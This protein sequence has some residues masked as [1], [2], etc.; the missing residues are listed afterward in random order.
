MNN[1]ERI[2][3]VAHNSYELAKEEKDHIKKLGMLEGIIEFTLNYL[4]EEVN[5]EL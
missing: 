2:I 3:K 4:K 5:D 1:I